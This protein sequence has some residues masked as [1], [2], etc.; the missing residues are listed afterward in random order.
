MKA[1]NIYG[2]PIYV[3][4]V[5]VDFP[6]LKI[7]LAHGGRPIWTDTAFFLVRRHKNVYMDISG[8]PPNRLLSYFPRLELIAAKT[9][10]GSDWAGPMVS[11]IRSNIDAFLSL[12]LSATIKQQ[13]LRET[14]LGLLKA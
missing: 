10:F 4:D 12:P 5:A 11:S 3:D 6:D 13:V 7:I 1:R 8:I 14:A 9:M 2:D